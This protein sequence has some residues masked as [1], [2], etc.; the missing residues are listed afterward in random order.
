MN[1]FLIIN[2]ISETLKKNHKHDS[3][4]LP[5]FNKKI[6]ISNKFFNELL[7]YE[8]LILTPKDLNTGIENFDELFHVEVNLIKYNIISKDNDSLVFMMLNDFGITSDTPF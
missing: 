8:E 3:L 1:H 4:K 6:K 5:F 7:E 2:E